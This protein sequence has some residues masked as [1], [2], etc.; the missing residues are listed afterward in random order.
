MLT[1][2]MLNVLTNLCI[3]D[4]PYCTVLYCTVLLPGLAFFTS[5]GARARRANSTDLLN[6]EICQRRAQSCFIFD[7][8]SRTVSSYA[9]AY[10]YAY[11]ILD[12]GILSN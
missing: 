10:A 9:Y 3:V 8:R 6:A 11:D 12:S 2:R 1:T 7:F 4:A 5:I